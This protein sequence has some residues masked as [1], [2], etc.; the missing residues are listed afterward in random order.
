MGFVAMYF[1]I[2]I[3]ANILYCIEADINSIRAF[4]DFKA[5]YSFIESHNLYICR[6]KISSDYFCDFIIDFDNG[7]ERRKKNRR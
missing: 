5:K 6:H 7:I 3:F 4:L 1:A 2:I